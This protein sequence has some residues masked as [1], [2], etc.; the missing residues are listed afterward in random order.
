MRVWTYRAGCHIRGQTMVSGEKDGM[1]QRRSQVILHLQE[2]DMEPLRADSMVLVMV[3]LTKVVR[4][5]N[6]AEI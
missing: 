5:S 1:R 2:G 3:E 6:R 4:A